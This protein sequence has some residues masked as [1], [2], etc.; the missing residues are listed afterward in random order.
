M[1]KVTVSVEDFLIDEILTIE[2]ELG[3]SGRVLVRHS[4]TEPVLR[5]MVE[6]ITHEQAENGAQRLVSA[7]ETFFASS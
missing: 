4:G 3:E 2:N 6:A 7:A 1:P 5:I